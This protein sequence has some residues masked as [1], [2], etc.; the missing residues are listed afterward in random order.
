MGLRF[1]E[2]I[3]KNHRS[4]FFKF[5]DGILYCHHLRSYKKNDKRIIAIGRSWLV[6]FGYVE[7]NTFEICS[8]RTIVPVEG[9][10]GVVL[11]P[12]SIIELNILPSDQEWH[13]F[14][15]LN[16]YPEEFPPEA[17][18]FNWN[19]TVPENF[20]QL[21]QVISEGT[22]F[23]NIEKVEVVSAVAYKVKDYILKNYNHKFS[24]IEISRMYNY[25]HPVMTRQFKKCFGLNPVEYRNMI[26]IFDSIPNMIQ[27]D[28]TV[29]KAAHMS[30]FSD[31]SSFYRQFKKYARLSPRKFCLN[32][33]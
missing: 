6:L 24:I 22:K 11:P 17:V 15:S 31:M 12:G 20:N 1:N 23:T 14:I 21:L 30:G 32:V 4:R 26:R 8:R 7:R 9:F 29:T 25:S 19:N 5:D 10:V 16:T 3:V 28:L 13:G 27:E 2:I 18:L 33:S